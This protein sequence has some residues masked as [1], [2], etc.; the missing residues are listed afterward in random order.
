MYRHA[1]ETPLTPPASYRSSPKP[2]LGSTTSRTS[3]SSFCYQRYSPYPRMRVEQEDDSEIEVL[4]DIRDVRLEEYRRK[5]QK[6]RSTSPYDELPTARPTFPTIT[7]ASEMRNQRRNMTHRRAYSMSTISYGYFLFPCQKQ[8]PS[9]SPPIQPSTP[10][11]TSSPFL[12]RQYLPRRA[13]TSSPLPARTRTRPFIAS[14][15]SRGSTTTPDPSKSNTAT[16]KLILVNPVVA[17]HLKHGGMVNI[18]SVDGQ[19]SFKVYLPHTK[20]GVEMVR[21]LATSS[22]C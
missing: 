18:R 8:K 15:P 9:Q 5:L 20:G 17:N 6:A 16:R 1:T 12:Y 22:T 19:K 21:S 4:R 13:Q 11:P 14:P 3:R 2:S 7:S 10:R